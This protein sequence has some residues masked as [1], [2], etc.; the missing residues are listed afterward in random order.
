MKSRIITCF[1]KLW[2]IW[3]VI[4]PG[5]GSDKSGFSLTAE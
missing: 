2:P 1:P 4:E 5:F 3:A